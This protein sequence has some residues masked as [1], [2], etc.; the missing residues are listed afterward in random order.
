M[1]SQGTAQG[2][3]QRAI[4]RRHLLAAEMA[5]REMDYVSLP[6][7]LALTLLIGEESPERYERAAAR[8]HAL[9][10]FEAKG[11]SLAESQFAL[12]ALAALVGPGAE[13]AAATLA[14]LART[15]GVNGVE[16]LLRD[17]HPS[18]MRAP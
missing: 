9:F 10:V 18:T 11:I 1:T 17:R 4:Q 7:A 14:H 6:N 12:A 16:V 2:R 13:S 5:V 15:F 8:W 3:F